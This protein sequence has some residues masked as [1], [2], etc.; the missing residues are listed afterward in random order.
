MKK[1]SQFSVLQGGAGGITIHPQLEA[2]SMS[3]Y[4]RGIGASSTKVSSSCPL[5]HS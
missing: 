3:A 2:P 4:G 1:R 5:T